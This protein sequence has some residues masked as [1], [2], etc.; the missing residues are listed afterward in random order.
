MLQRGLCREASTECCRRQERPGVAY[1]V[2]GVLPGG[3]ATRVHD[4]G[5]DGPRLLESR[6]A[7]GLPVPLV[8]TARARCVSKCEQDGPPQRFPRRA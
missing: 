1:A 8:L 2:S 5:D 4:G 3:E 7:A 6:E